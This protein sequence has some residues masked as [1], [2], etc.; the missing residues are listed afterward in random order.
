MTLSDLEIQ[1]Y[2]VFVIFFAISGYDAYSTSELRRNWAPTGDRPRQAV[3]MQ[4]SAQSVD[5]NSQVSTDY[6]Q[7]VL[8]SVKSVQKQQ[9]PKLVD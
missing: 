2:R 1:K 8:R 7:R 6:V 5:V 9:G 3:Y 4:C